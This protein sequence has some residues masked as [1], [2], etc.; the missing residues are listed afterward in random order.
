MSEARAILERGLEAL[1]LDASEVQRGALLALAELTD[2][3]G[4]RLNLTGHR[5]A[6]EIVERL[7]L[8]AA[9]LATV[10]PSGERLADLGAGAGYPGLPLA[11]L[12]PELQVTLVE[13]RE[14]RHHFQKAARRELGLGNATPL[15]GRAEDLE[16]TPHDI[17]IA[18]A[19]AQPEQALAWM[20]PW[21]APNAWLL[22]P[23]GPTPP[24]IPAPTDG[25]WQPANPVPYKSPSAATPART[26]WQ[27]RRGT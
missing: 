12:R 10:L 1:A 13:A 2:A 23:S 3:W 14:R 11:I 20:L 26:L 4:Q 15:L 16:A 17:V 6:A 7:V 9:A 8:D 22:I 18:Q 27:A 21:C 5:G 19:M 25:S 24:N